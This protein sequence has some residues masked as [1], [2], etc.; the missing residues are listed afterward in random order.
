[1]EGPTPFEQ[2][3][4]PLTGDRDRR[5]RRLTGIQKAVLILGGVIFWAPILL[6]PVFMEV[7]D[8]ARYGRAVGGS[9]VAFLVVVGVAA[10]IDRASRRWSRWP[11]VTALLAVACVVLSIFVM[12]FN[13][14]VAEK[15]LYARIARQFAEFNIAFDSQ[16]A[17]IKKIK[18][19]DGGHAELASVAKAAAAKL[20]TLAKGL[21]AR[22]TIHKLVL[23]DEL[24]RMYETGELYQSLVATYE[25]LGGLN[26]EN[27]TS[28][29]DI[30][31]RRECLSAVI[32]EHTAYMDSM[33]GIPHR[34][35]QRLKDAGAEAM[36]ADPEIEAFLSS[37]STE[38]LG[39]RVHVVEQ[40]ILESHT[41]YWRIL[42]E[43]WGNWVRDGD[44]A[45]FT[46]TD[47]DRWIVEFDA[48]CKHIAALRERQLQMKATRVKSGQN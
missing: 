34:V 48:A 3:L 9:F 19:R 6:V 36:L 27:V 39:Y 38:G 4:P 1:M 7:H 29:A 28:V 12:V 30:E 25:A 13:R 37:M 26:A 17:E 20:N 18:D 43:A 40:E 2:A 35:T 44:V 16:L 21:P 5:A 8:Y 45:R 14:A 10:L 15:Q 23:A 31:R 47:A 33:A 11:G 42:H 46:G 41:T 32:A 24:A 22:D